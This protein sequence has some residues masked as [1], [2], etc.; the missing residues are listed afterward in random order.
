MTHPERIYPEE[1]AED[2]GFSLR[3]R[4]SAICWPAILSVLIC[5]SVSADSLASLKSS[6]LPPPFLT[7]TSL[8]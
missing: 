4:H 2:L 1:I 8:A 5:P 6:L 3:S 7:D